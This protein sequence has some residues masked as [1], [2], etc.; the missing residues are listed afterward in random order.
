MY[1]R[2]YEPPMR[3]RGNSP[4]ARCDTAC[5]R[6]TAR[7]FAAFSMWVPDRGFGNATGAQGAPT[8]SRAETRKLHSMGTCEHS[9]VVHGPT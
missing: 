1:E 6:P 2:E 3:F 5:H 9:G 4:R 7:L 8:N